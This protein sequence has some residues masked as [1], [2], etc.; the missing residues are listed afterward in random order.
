M[1]KTTILLL[2]LLITTTI[3]SQEIVRI[4]DSTSQDV[5]PGATNRWPVSHLNSAL[6]VEVL[7]SAPGN[8]R[9]HY[10]TGFIM[11]GAKDPNG[12]YLLRQN[13]L[14]FN[15][16]ADTLTA[17]EDGTTFDVDTLA[18]IGDFCL[19]LW[20]NLPATADDV[21]LL[22]ES[23][24]P[25]NNG[26]IIQLSA[27]SLITFTID[28]G[29]NT[30]TIT[31]TTVL[32]DGE[33][34]HIACSVDRDSATGMQIYVDGEADATAV[35]P[36]TVTAAINAGDDIVITG[37]DAVTF[38]ISTMGFYMGDGAY[39]TPTEARERYNSGIGHKY[40]GD[41][42]DLIVGYNTDEGIGNGCLDIL[43]KIA[44]V[45]ALNTVT[46]APSRQSGSTAEVNVMGVPI[47][48][49]PWDMM[50]SVGKFT[51]GGDLLSGEHRGNIFIKFPHPVR[52]GRNCPLIILETIGGFNLILFGFTGPY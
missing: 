43:D 52:I 31:G 49:G 24:N 48:S 20:I 18:A 15:A 37:D 45:I 30:A 6:G 12:F 50:R 17:T 14:V 8:S 51:C 10:V 25:L 33:W 36:T 26:W 16:T 34:H 35:D 39:F 13:C 7:L 21:P 2:V 11:T 9:S 4:Y 3:F 32:D 19:E 5:N 42:L 1:K 47:S 22:V 41:E 23:G 29:T 46:W 40:E 44:N 28:D 38:Y 27:S